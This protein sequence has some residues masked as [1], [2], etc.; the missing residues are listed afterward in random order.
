MID[1]KEIKRIKSINNPSDIVKELQLYREKIDNAVEH[2]EI[3]FK[4]KILNSIF[5]II[6]K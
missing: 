6:K 5:R 4:E 2:E 1:K 3:P